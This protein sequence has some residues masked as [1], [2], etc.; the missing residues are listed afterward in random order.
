MFNKNW[1]LTAWRILVVEVA[2]MYYTP[3]PFITLIS[4][5][6]NLLSGQQC[7]RLS[8]LLFLLFVYWL[9]LWSDD[10]WHNRLRF[11]HWYY[12]HYS[13]S[14]YSMT[15]LLKLCGRTGCS[16]IANSCVYM[17][18]RQTNIYTSIQHV[19]TPTSR[20][21]FK[22]FA[23][24]DAS[25]DFVMF[26]PTRWWLPSERTGSSCSGFQSVRDNFL[27]IRT[28]PIGDPWND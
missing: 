23:L 15:L 24:P 3:I 22:F 4:I 6:S 26:L 21:S 10:V 9:L 2:F 12:H 20:S 18:D 14:S 28:V 17:T 16:H 27:E 5:S 19:C 25:F 13:A 1:T 7:R 11:H 8:V